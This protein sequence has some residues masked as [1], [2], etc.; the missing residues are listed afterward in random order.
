M[1]T[2]EGPE[3]STHSAR[4]PSKASILLRAP[5]A[6]NRN[7]LTDLSRKGILKNMSLYMSQCPC[8]FLGVKSRKGAGAK[9]VTYSTIQPTTA[10][11]TYAMQYQRPQLR[12]Y[13]AHPNLRQRSSSLPHLLSSCFLSKFKADA[14]TDRGS[15]IHCYCK[16]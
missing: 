1:S 10:V 7:G 4:L 16:R 9:M 14:V 11:P 8:K 12:P 13:S 2:S 15:V 3:S 6:I 5:V